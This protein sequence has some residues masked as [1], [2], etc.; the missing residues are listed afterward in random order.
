M[1]GRETKQPEGTENLPL[2]MV[3]WVLGLPRLVRI[4]IAAFFALATTFALREVVD[5]IYIEY[6]FSESTRILPSFVSAG[7]GLLMYVIGWQLIVG[8][9]GEDRQAKMATVGYFVIGLFALLLVGFWFLRLVLLQNQ[10][11]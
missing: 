2:R 7:F 11:A 1:A 10:S 4:L 3:G 9:I 8:T 5:E 6:F